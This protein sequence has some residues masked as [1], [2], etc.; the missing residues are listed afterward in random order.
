MYLNMGGNNYSQE[1]ANENICI[2]AAKGP[3]FE[4]FFEE[5]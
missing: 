3:H 2:L 5:R 4:L 1:G